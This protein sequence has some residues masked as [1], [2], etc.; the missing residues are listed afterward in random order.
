MGSSPMSYRIYQAMLSLFS[1]RASLGECDFTLHS[2]VKSNEE[3]RV[4]GDW[5]SEAVY[6]YFKTPLQV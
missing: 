4:M 2:N 5:A 3:I 6:A 1:D